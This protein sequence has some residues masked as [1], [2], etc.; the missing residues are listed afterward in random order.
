M[1]SEIYRKKLPGLV[2]AG[3]VPQSVLDEAVRRTL[4]LKYRLGLFQNPYRVATAAQ[5]QAITLSASHRA[6]AREVARESIVLLKND[7]NVLPLSKNVRTLA[8]SAH[9][10]GQRCGAWNWT[11]GG[12]AE[13]PCQCSLYQARGVAANASMY[14]RGASPVN[15]STRGIPQR[16]VCA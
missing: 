14:S 15:D 2:R 3:T 12:R 11:A 1:V 16:W 5:A 9:W 7:R 8:V 4:R 6:A 13:R 10:R